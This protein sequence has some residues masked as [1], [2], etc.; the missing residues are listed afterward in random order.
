MN[1]L[2]SDSIEEI[3]ETETFKTMFMVHTGFVY[4]EQ[5]V[6]LMRDI[7]TILYDSEYVH[8]HEIR[9]EIILAVYTNSNRASEV[10]AI[11][12]KEILLN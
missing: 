11:I 9:N 1:E 2:T 8:A 6:T 4:L 5:T 3:E 7:Y 12:K 10:E